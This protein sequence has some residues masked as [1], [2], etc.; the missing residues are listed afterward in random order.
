MASFCCK[1]ARASPNVT[2]VRQIYSWPKGIL[3]VSVRGNGQPYITRYEFESWVF[4]WTGQP[5][6]RTRF[7]FLYSFS[8]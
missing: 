8:Y 4:W 6:S 7:F 5:S 2:R 3:A 1:T